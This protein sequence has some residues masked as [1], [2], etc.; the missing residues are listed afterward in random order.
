MAPRIH[1]FANC[2]RARGTDRRTDARDYYKEIAVD[3]LR[4]ENVSNERGSANNEECE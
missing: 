4:H 2:H 3:Q 1:Q